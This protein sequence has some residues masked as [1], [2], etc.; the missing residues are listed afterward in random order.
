IS[1]TFLKK[2]KR[3]ARCLKRFGGQTRVPTRPQAGPTTKSVLPEKSHQT[4]PRF[5]LATR[6]SLGNTVE[7]LLLSKPNAVATVAKYGSIAVGG[8]QRPVLVSSGP[9]TASVGNVP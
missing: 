9:F 5:G 4:N 6:P 1:R 8:I 7:R 3:D 2:F